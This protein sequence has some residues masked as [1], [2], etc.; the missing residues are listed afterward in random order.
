MYLTSSC[1]PSAA[2]HLSS[3]PSV[4]L[5]CERGICF[6]YQVPPWIASGLIFAVP[7]KWNIEWHEFVLLILCFLRKSWQSSWSL[8][9]KHHINTL[10]S[11]GLKDFLWKHRKFKYSSSGRERVELQKD[12]TTDPKTTQEFLNGCCCSGFWLV[13]SAAIQK[14]MARVCCCQLCGSLSCWNICFTGLLNEILWHPWTTR[15]SGMDK[16]LSVPILLLSDLPTNPPCRHSSIWR[17]LKQNSSDD[18]MKNVRNVNCSP[19]WIKLSSREEEE[20]EISSLWTDDRVFVA[21][22]LRW[23]LL[24]N[25]NII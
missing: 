23:S 2:D 19:E 14:L 7:E 20:E 6:P 8:L 15:F 17:G 21:G 11:S 10:G 1:F 3:K 13:W 4:K 9:N 12:N 24:Q 5:G 18:C 16:S 25:N 22:L